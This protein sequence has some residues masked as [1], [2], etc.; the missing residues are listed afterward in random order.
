MYLRISPLSFRVSLSVRIGVDAKG[1]AG[2]LTGPPSVSPENIAQPPKEVLLVCGFI[3]VRFLD[4]PLSKTDGCAC[5]RNQSPRKTRACTVP[6]TKLKGVHRTYP[7]RQHINPCHSFGTFLF[8]LEN[9]Q[10]FPKAY[11]TQFFSR[12]YTSF[13]R[14]AILVVCPHMYFAFAASFPHANKSYSEG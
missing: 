5:G 1:S 10:P 11:L 7:L 12:E 13:A 4:C 3:L 8:P 9:I 6:E 2:A 14:I